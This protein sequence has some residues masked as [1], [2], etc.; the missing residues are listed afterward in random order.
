MQKNADICLFREKLVPKIIAKVYMA[1]IVGWLS[2]LGPG[3]S[4]FFPYS[5]TSPPSVF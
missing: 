4:P 5:L 2:R 3:Q 1:R